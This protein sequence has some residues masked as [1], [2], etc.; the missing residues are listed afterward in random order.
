MLVHCR[1]TPNIKLGGTHLYTW[2]ERSTMRVKCLAQEH[3]TMFLAMARTQTAQ[4][5]VEC[6]NHEIT[7]PPLSYSVPNE[8]LPRYIALMYNL[9][10]NFEANNYNKNVLSTVTYFCVNYTFV[11]GC[12]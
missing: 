6:T 9:I 12:I 2:V 7:T 10:T 1:V 5:R 3:K 4:S 8:N 11:D